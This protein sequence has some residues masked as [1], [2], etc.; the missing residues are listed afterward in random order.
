MWSEKNSR[1]QIAIEIR[2]K[3]SNQEKKTKIRNQK[4][5]RSESR[6]PNQFQIE[7]VKQYQLENTRDHKKPE[8]IKHSEKPK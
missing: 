1:N 7:T 3:P 6:D 2:N 8:I 4:T 5:L